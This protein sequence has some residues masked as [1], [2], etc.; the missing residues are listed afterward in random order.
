MCTACGAPALS[1]GAAASK[2]KHSLGWP[3]RRPARLGV[4]VV[5][6]T[7]AAASGGLRSRRAGRAQ[8]LRA[9]PAERYGR[10]LAMGTRGVSL[11]SPGPDLPDTSTDRT[12][13]RP[14]LPC[15]A[16]PPKH[17][18]SEPS[19]VT[20]TQLCRALTT[21]VGGHWQGHCR[22]VQLDFWKELEGPLTLLVQ[23]EVCTPLSGHAIGYT[24]PRLFHLRS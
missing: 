6:G 17:Q 7:A 21:H 23:I 19:R 4:G 5:A 20:V 14:A 8:P 2:G 10:C 15:P 16:P 3:D 18:F 24:I 12:R 11:G 1:A 13:T 9:S 22:F